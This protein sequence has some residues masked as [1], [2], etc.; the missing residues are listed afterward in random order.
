MVRVVRT[1][2]IYNSLGFSDDS[3]KPKWMIGIQNG[4]EAKRKKRRKSKRVRKNPP[5]PIA[6]PSFVAQDGKGVELL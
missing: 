1:P 4:S 6:P 3:G 2:D 5:P